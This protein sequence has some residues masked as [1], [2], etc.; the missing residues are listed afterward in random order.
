MMTFREQ[1]LR[2]HST[3]QDLH[4][5]FELFYVPWE[6]EAK[7]ELMM[8]ETFKGT[9]SAGNWRVRVGGRRKSHQTMKH[10]WSWVKE[11]REK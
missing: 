1:W 7:M 11:R 6:V 8:Q 4:R 2:I 3:F 10:I 5:L 9:I